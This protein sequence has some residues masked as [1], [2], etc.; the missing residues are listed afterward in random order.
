MYICSKIFINMKKKISILFA[1]FV[2]CAISASATGISKSKAQAKA[3]SFFQKG[4]M[5]DLSKGAEVKLVK[6]YASSE[7]APAAVF[8][9]SRGENVVFVSA[10]DKMPAILGYSSNADVNNLPPALEAMLRYYAQLTDAVREGRIEAPK[11][12]ASAETVDSL[13]HTCWNQCEPFCSLCPYYNGEQTPNG[14]VSTAF[15]QVMK[16]HKWPVKPTGKTPAYTTMTR[17]I[18]MPEIDLESHTYNWADMID[19]YKEGT[20]TEEQA[21]AVAQ[22]CYDVS[23]ASEMDYDI[24]GSGT[25]YGYAAEAM[26][27]YFKYNKGF[28][29]DYAEFNTEEEWV[30]K[31]KNE[32]NQGRPL[33]YDAQTDTYPQNGHCFVIDGYDAEGLFHVNWG[34]GGRSNG[35]FLITTLDPKEQGIGGATSGKGFSMR[36]RTLFDFVPDRDGTSTPVE[37]FFFRYVNC[38]A[39]QGSDITLKTLTNW[40]VTEFHGDLIMQVAD[41]EGNVIGQQTIMKDVHS[42]IDRE[43]DQP[44]TL[45]DFDFSGYGDG[46]YYTEF[47]FVSSATGE[48]YRAKHVKPNC[49]IVVE[50][51]K[52]KSILNSAILEG[53]ITS[54][55]VTNYE[56]EELSLKIKSQVTNVDDINFEKDYQINVMAKCYCP[57]NGKSDSDYGKCVT[58]LE[59][60]KSITFEND[61]TIYLI[62]ILDNLDSAMFQMSLFYP[63]G[64]LDVKE[65][66]LKSLL[67]TGI[68]DINVDSQRPAKRLDSNRH[69]VICKGDKVYNVVGRRIN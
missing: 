14:C 45:K 48:E 66:P 63:N 39:Y 55:E 50:N 46:T 27:T 37:K 61:L 4:F 64:E 1:V 60:G 8:A 2:L 21:Q 26:R 16:Y 18:E 44:A 68:K 12:Y 20:Y 41:K 25:A 28:R 67:P 54:C 13:L 69:I 34:W 62:S 49:R 57:E 23:A 35:C 42:T 38:E 31:L 29:I 56:D 58:L 7:E 3:A 30:A 10:E 59:P 47:I 51:G 9:F 40:G 52:L 32:L 15:A 33:P 24:D 5:K 53:K 11:L 17:K 6:E 43:H 65:Y 19:I 36:Q 22:L